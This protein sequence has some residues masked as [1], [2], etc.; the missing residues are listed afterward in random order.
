MSELSI[1]ILVSI[2][3]YTAITIINIF[4]NRPRY[5]FQEEENKG[6]NIKQIGYLNTYDGSCV[7]PNEENKIKKQI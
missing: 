4:I 3:C 6:A 5:E 2:V 1:V 7:L